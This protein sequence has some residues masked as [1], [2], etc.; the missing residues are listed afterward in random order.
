MLDLKQI[1]CFHLSLMT[2]IVFIP[3]AAAICMTAWP[4]PLLAAF[5]ITESPAQA[6]D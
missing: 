4:T 1:Q 6:T 3:L 5:W 2:L